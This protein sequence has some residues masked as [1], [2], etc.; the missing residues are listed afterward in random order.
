MCFTYKSRD[1]RRGQTLWGASLDCPALTQ[2]LFAPLRTVIL[3]HLS[4]AALKQCSIVS[5]M[6]MYGSE[7]HECDGL[8][9]F[10]RK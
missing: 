8:T 7:L 4:R 1:C 9:D 3:Q 10:A 6:Q 5:K 2:A